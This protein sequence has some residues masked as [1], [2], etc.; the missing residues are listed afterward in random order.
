M[1]VWGRQRG[2]REGEGRSRLYPTRVIGDTVHCCS[3]ST[4]GH[5]KAT[6]MDVRRLTI[7]LFFIAHTIIRALLIEGEKKTPQKKVFAST[8]KFC[9]FY[10]VS[11]NQSMN[12]LNGLLFYI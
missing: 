4:L 2:G 3:K 10:I 1:E 9:I 8:I 6:F 12:L 11:R 7:M 5:G